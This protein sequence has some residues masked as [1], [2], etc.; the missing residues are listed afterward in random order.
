MTAGVAHELNNPLTYVVASHEFIRD[1]LMSLRD[2][3]AAGNDISD[4]ALKD[5]I[6]A[7]EDLAEGLARFRSVVADLGQISRGHK[8][9]KAN[10]VDVRETMR[11]SVKM[12][13]HQVA[14]HARIEESYGEVPPVSADASRLGQVFL[15]LIINAS[16]A[17]PTG[18]P[19]RN[20][21]RLN[22][23]DELVPSLAHAEPDILSIEI[24]RKAGHEYKRDYRY[25]HQQAL[26]TAQ[27]PL[28]AIASIHQTSPIPLAQVGA[29]G[30]YLHNNSIP[31]DV[32][33][34]TV[35]VAATHD[36]VEKIIVADLHPQKLLRLFKSSN[37]Y[38]TSLI[39]SHGNV[40]LHSNNKKNAR[41]GET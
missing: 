29:M 35:A 4:E 36:G 26:D 5:A 33:I 9:G 15:N 38:E 11:S 6:S 22:T 24:W 1:F 30:I 3:P 14:G 23:F 34:L 10:S 21:I 41:P 7:T 40:L 25:I 31:P 28:Q 27:L 37:L 2:S 13:S 16:Q 39:D 8:A 32:A 12:A 19:E 18:Q 20:E 17:L